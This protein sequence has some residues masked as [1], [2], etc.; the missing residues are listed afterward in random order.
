[1]P[2][3]DFFG[4]SDRVRQLTAPVGMEA[5]H[6]DGFTWARQGTSWNDTTRIGPAEWNRLIGNLRGIGLMPDT[7]SNEFDPAGPYVLRDALI[8]FV[9]ERVDIHI[10][11][12][13]ESVNDALALKAPLASPAFSGT[14]TAPTPSNATNSTRIATT[15]YV[16]ALFSDLY[17]GSV[18]AGFDTIFEI[19]GVM[20]TKA[21]LA[22]PALTGTPTA[23][24]P[25]N[26]DN[27]T[28]LATTA[29]VKA[30]FSDLYGG[31]V[32]AGFDTI[33]EI[34][35]VVG[36][37]APLASP[38]LT[39]TPT[40]P[41][42]ATPTN[43]TQLA[44]TAF[45][46]A[47]VAALVD[48][49]PAALNTLN[50]LAAAL[51]DDPNFA[52]TITNALALKAPLASPALTGVPT[53]PTASAATSTTQIATTAFVK[54]LFNDLY[55]G[56]VSAGF[57]TLLEIEGVLGTKAPLA[58]PAFTGTPTAPTPSNADNSTKLATTAYVKALFSDL[59]GGS[60]GA[61]FD[62]L[63]EIEAAVGAKAPLASPALTGVPTAPTA[64]GG[65]NTTQLATTAFVTAGL[66]PKAPLASPA[67]TGTPTAPTPAN[68]D[69]ST[70]LATTAYVKA[71]FDDLYGGSVGAGFDTLV[72][73][74]AV[75]AANLAT[76]LNSGNQNAGTLP[77]ARLPTR[78]GVYSKTVADWNNAVEN[79]WYMSGSATNAPSAGW[80]VGHVEAHNALYCT[81]TLHLFTADSSTD[82]NTW[83]RELNNGTWGAWYRLRI[84]QGELDARYAQL[85]S[86][87]L[88]G[89][90]TAPTPANSDNSTKL[91]TTA[92]VKALFDDLYGGSVSSGFD[93]L[94][95]IEA[96]LGGKAPLAS[97]ALTGV[98]TAP[99]AAG[100]T[101]TTQLATTAFV[102]AGLAPKAPLASPALTGTPTA[103]TPAN[104]TNTTQIATTAYVKA[105]FSDLYGGSVSAGFDT[106]AEIEA[107]VGA[108]QAAALNSSNQNA[109]TLPNAR[110]PTRLQE[111]AAA[112]TDFD[113]AVTNGWYA[114][115]DPANNPTGETSAWWICQVSGYTSSHLIQTAWNMF[116][117]TDADTMAYRRR[118]SSGT[119]GAWYRIR[120][121]QTELDTRYSVKE[122]GDWTPTFEG[123][124]IGGAIS[125]YA[126]VGKYVAAGRLVLVTFDV[127]AGAM[128]TTTPT[129]SLLIAG[130]P[131]SSDESTAALGGGGIGFAGAIQNLP[132]NFG[133]WNMRRSTAN[134]LAVHFTNTST[135]ATAAAN[136]NILTDGTRFIGSF[137]YRRA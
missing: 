115:V 83:R 117:G 15:A 30:L 118:R 10:A 43:T 25:S 51:G 100:G 67:L 59:Y 40:A 71:L 16:K 34:E 11:P 5:V 39:G 77:D 126:Q 46:Q 61:G 81:Q 79:G 50:E 21:P 58:S 110:L 108:N 18:S 26:A 111:G 78:L 65:T 45:V 4:I 55:G 121:S 112:L 87:A 48:S 135:G 91:A 6:E 120:L 99:T 23:P 130:L 125:Y 53:A 102:T 33:V 98:P 31:S 123:T 89:T 13:M 52:T 129:G 9:T 54:G 119:W 66:A 19:E 94:V 38:A 131:L 29:Y 35:A 124:T 72:E 122:A 93:T 109:G 42:A 95:E 14:P 85:A 12:Y 69:N 37:K 88:T 73:I 113:A 49:S 28:K 84:A 105:L 116:G 74:E 44:T 2:S 134:K 128:F 82:T 24:T 3:P 41:T 57:D 101:N 64:A 132:A 137:V 56:S 47:V 70:K 97:P 76:A 8:S 127:H 106:I 7:V 114:G 22:S 68:S 32:S 75:V 107:V 90:P 104:A 80:F 63:V 17:G 27:S 136:A 133:G 36:S 103:P 62:T 96:A 20:A 1:M 86:P 92:Y 60:V